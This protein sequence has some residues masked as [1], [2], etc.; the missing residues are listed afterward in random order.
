MSNDE[1]PHKMTA[2][3]AREIGNLLIQFEE[4]LKKYRWVRLFWNDGPRRSESDNIL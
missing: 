1:Y 4:A 3:E 2:E